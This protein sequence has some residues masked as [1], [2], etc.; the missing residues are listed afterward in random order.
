M[1]KYIVFV[2]ILWYFVNVKQI[3]LE[4]KSMKQDLIIETKDRRNKAIEEG[5]D[6]EKIYSMSLEL[7]ELIAKYY[8]GRKR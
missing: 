3:M 8:L 4:V 2:Q 5:E 7:D 1:S 6:F